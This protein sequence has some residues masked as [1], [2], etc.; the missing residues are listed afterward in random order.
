[1]RKNYNKNN[2]FYNRIINLK[3]IK[4][5]QY[6]QKIQEEKLNKQNIRKNDIDMN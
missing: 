3:N 2:I 4:I 6:F 5:Q 1:M